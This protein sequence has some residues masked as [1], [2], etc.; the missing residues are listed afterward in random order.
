LGKGHAPYPRETAGGPLG[1]DPREWQKPGLRILMAAS[2]LSHNT[3]T[4]QNARVGER[5]E[6]H[7]LV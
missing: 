3:A 5:W 1:T 4:W 7:Y 6:R 2:E